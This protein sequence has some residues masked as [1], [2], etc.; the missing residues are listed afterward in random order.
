MCC[1]RRRTAWCHN[2][3]LRPPDH[4][5]DRVVTVDLGNDGIAP[6]V[7]FASGTATAVVGPNGGGGKVLRG[8]SWLN[9]GNGVCRCAV[10]GGNVP[11]S[12]FNYLGF[13]LAA[14]GQ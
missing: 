12:R 2:E 9:W 4:L 6:T 11:S 1:S 8:S 3:I 10:R 5:Y 14:P 13:R 7:T